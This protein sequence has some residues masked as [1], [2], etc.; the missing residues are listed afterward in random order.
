MREYKFRGKRLDTGEWIYGSYVYEPY[1]PN[2]IS[3]WNDITYTRYEVDED[4]VGQ[5]T[6]LKDKNGVEIYEDDIVSRVGGGLLGSPSQILFTGVVVF[7]KHGY[8]AKHFTPSP[9]SGGNRID[10]SYGNLFNE[11]ELEAIGNTHDN[12]NLTKQQETK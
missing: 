7:T 11:D 5:Y 6:G 2:T 10:V 9:G 1:G 3:D 12:P 4:T 8:K